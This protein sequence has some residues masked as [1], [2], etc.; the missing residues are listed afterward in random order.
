MGWRTALGESPAIVAILAGVV[1]VL[2]IALAGVITIAAV[3][4]TE[5]QTIASVV[6]AASAVVGSII[7]AFFG[8][9]MGAEGRDAALAQAQESSARAVA[10]AAHLEPAKVQDAMGTVRTLTGGA[11][12]PP[13]DE[14]AAA[15]GN[16]STKG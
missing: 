1:A 6:A 12:P 5:G 13:A 3:G 11:G 4:G 8:V 2:L 15:A 14:A 9:R 10:F 16:Q 7:G